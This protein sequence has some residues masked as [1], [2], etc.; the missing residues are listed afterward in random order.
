MNTELRQMQ[1]M[2]SKNIN[3]EN[4]KVKDTKKSAVKRKL[5]FEVYQHC[6]EVTQLEKKNK[7]FRKK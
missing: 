4:K 6:L 5:K 3:N 2:I 7:V 1:K